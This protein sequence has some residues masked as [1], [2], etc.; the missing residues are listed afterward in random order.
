MATLVEP[1]LSD[2]IEGHENS[3]DSNVPFVSIEFF[4]PRT[5]VGI[6]SLYSVLNKLTLRPHPNESAIPLFVDFTWGA[7]GST[8]DLTIE[9][10]TKAK[11]EHGAVCNMHLTC[12]NVSR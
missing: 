7:G 6:T 9:L 12:T 2:L 1:K 3:S 4:P 11:Q 8:S 10:C 5:E